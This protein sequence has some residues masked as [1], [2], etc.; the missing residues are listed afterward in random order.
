[1]D[2]LPVNSSYIAAIGYDPEKKVAHVEFKNGGSYRY[3]NVDPAH[4]E[5]MKN[6][7]SVGKHF[8]STFKKAYTGTPFV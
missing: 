2:M 6:A 1:M 7:E 3:E 4:F 8:H 5:D